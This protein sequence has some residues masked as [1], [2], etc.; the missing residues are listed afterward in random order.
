MTAEALGSYKQTMD[1][2]GRVHVNGPMWDYFEKEK[3][4]DK[5]LVQINIHKD[6][7][8]E[9]KEEVEEEPTYCHIGFPTDPT[10]PALILL[11]DTTANKK[12]R[13][14]KK[15]DMEQLYDLPSRQSE[16]TSERIHNRYRK[17]EIRSKKIQLSVKE[18]NFLKLPENDNSV[19]IEGRGVKFAL[20]AASEYADR[21][22]DNYSVF[23]FEDEKPIRKKKP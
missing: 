13:E 21:F 6:N 12:S 11:N 4:A 15:R 7:T 1:G 9:E 3:K 14:T 8:V 2:A 22:P 10:V 19:I 5:K 20:W 16:D 18:R 23:D 17:V